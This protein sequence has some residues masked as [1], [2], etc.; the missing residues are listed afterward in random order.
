MWSEWNAWTYER[1]RE[2]A[3]VLLAFQETTVLEGR[4]KPTSWNKSC[5]RSEMKSYEPSGRKA[6]L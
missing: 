3:V 6:C 4:L 1:L 2:G 5:C